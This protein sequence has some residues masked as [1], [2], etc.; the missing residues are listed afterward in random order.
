MGR[1]YISICLHACAAPALTGALWARQHGHLLPFSWCTWSRLVPSSPVQMRPHAAA[2][3]WDAH[4]GV[5][6]QRRVAPELCALQAYRG[7]SFAAAVS[8]GGFLR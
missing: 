8:S 5:L 7:P 2:G 3:S 4:Q 1:H 6:A